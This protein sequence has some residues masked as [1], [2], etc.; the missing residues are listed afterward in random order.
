MTAKGDGNDEV[1]IG[2]GYTQVNSEKMVAPN[3]LHI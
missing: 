2:D 3:H 1:V